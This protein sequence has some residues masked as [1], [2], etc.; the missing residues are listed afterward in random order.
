[1]ILR[2]APDHIRNQLFN[3]LVSE[4]DLI[5]MGTYRVMYGH[6]V[7]S[8]FVGS[9]GVELD[10]CGGGNW[11]DVERL[12][13]LMYAVLT[14]IPETQECFDNVPHWSTVKPFF[15]DLEFV[16][17]VMNLAGPDI[18]QFT[19]ELLPRLSYDFAF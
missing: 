8:G 1:M 7:R 4:N 5:E 3:R 2:P 17:K 19:L 9:P 18:K 11:A 12:Y 6:R 16:G 15:L 13:S 10:W 14:R